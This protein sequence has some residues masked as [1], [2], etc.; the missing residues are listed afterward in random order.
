MILN[1]IPSFH[2]RLFFFIVHSSELDSLKFLQGYILGNPKTDDYIDS[3]SLVPYAFRVTLIPP[4]L[5]RVNID[6]HLSIQFSL[7]LITQNSNI[8]HYKTLLIL[9]FNFQSAKYYCNGDY[10]NI[11]ESN[12]ACVAAID[13]Y[14]QVRTKKKKKKKLSL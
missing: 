5:Y 2:L 13:A 14:D 12:T 6:L 7:N 1:V 4:E 9:S 8:F 10:V 3:N 11:N